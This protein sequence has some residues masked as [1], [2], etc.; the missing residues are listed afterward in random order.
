MEKNLRHCANGSYHIKGIDFD[1]PYILVAHSD[2][3]R[4]NIAIVAIHVL[5][6]R[7]LDVSN[8]FL[9]SLCQSTTLLSR[10]V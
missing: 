6:A 10:M 9:N 7:I 3:F 4:I 1:K 8:V 2:S 5:A